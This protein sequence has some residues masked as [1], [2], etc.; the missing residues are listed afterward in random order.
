MGDNPITSVGMRM[1]SPA[2][3]CG[4][5]TAA[6]SMSVLLAGCTTLEVEPEGVMV[7]P[8]HSASG[9]AWRYRST[10]GA[11]EIL[12]GS[13]HARYREDLGVIRSIWSGLP[14][15]GANV[16]VVRDDVSEVLLITMGRSALAT[17]NP[18]RGGPR[19]WWFHEIYPRL[20]ET[21]SLIRSGTEGGY[22]HS[23]HL[24]ARESEGSLVFDS[25]TNAQIRLRYLAKWLIEDGLDPRMVTAQVVESEG[26]MPGMWELAIALRPYQYGQELL[27]ETFLPPWLY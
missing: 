16:R 20:Q 12:V 10:Q 27:A 2:L 9:A 18:F 24:A 8:G 14:G 17:D 13:E 3:K 22:H 11:E 23:L 19:Q 15:A 1:A 5:F 21:A 4:V 25:K 7:H 26:E 6:M